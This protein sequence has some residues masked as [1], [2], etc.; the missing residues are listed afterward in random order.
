MRR[1]RWWLVGVF[2]SAVSFLF[3]AVPCA[4]NPMASGL[5]YLA[6]PNFLLLW[7]AC[8]LIEAVL[9]MGFLRPRFVSVG[10]QILPFLAIYFLNFT[11]IGPTSLLGVVIID[12]SAR[13]YLY[14]P[15]FWY[16]AE[17][18]PLV[19]ESF[20]LI[21]LFDQLYKRGYL[22]SPVSPRYTLLLVLTANLLTFFIGLLFVRYWPSWYY[23]MP[24]GA[25]V[26]GPPWFRY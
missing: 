4:A 24:G 13:G 14:P 20:V 23:P 22:R 18:F 9:I 11:T 5:S 15:E 10:K 26:Y 19:V 17:F 8:P 21:L 2:L 1:N 7:L 25:R 3:F 16:I 12:Q 6:S